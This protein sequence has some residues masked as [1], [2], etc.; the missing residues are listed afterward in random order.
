MQREKKPHMT[1]RH[2]ASHVAVFNFNAYSSAEIQALIE[3]VGVKKATFPVLPCFMLAV[4]AGGSIGFGAMYYC[5]VASD[6]ALSFAVVRVMGGIVFSLGLAIIMISG[7]ELFTGSNLIVMA[8]SAV[9]WATIKRGLAQLRLQN[10]TK[11]ERRPT[12]NLDFLQLTNF[13]LGIDGEGLSLLA[14]NAPRLCECCH[15]NE[16]IPVRHVEPNAIAVSTL[17]K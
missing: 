10:E 5:I 14:A 1:G 15:R 11:L 6:A 13:T 12:N 9:Y 3:A 16:R 17:E 2:P 7:A 4:V 8:W